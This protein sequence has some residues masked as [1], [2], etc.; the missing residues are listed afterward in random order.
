MTLETSHVNISL[1]LGYWNPYRVICLIEYVPEGVFH[2]LNLKHYF[3]SSTSTL[4]FKIISGFGLITVPLLLLLIFNNWYAMKVVCN[5]VAAS[6]QSI[7]QIHSNQV[8]NVLNDMAKYLHSMAYQDQNI[9]YI[10]QGKTTTEDDIVANLRLL[11]KIKKDVM[12]YSYANAIFLYKISE[13]VI[14]APKKESDY[15][16][17][18]SKLESLLKNNDTRL[19]CISNW[20]LFNMDGKY[21]LLKLTDTGFGTYIGV[22]VNLEELLQP[23]RFLEFS[24]NSQVMFASTEGQ[25]LT[26][27][28]SAHPLKTYRAD[29]LKKALTQDTRPYVIIKNEID[30]SDSMAVSIHSEVSDLYLVVV[31]PV[32][33]LV[34]KLTVFQS[35]VYVTPFVAAI[36]LAIFLLYL[37]RAIAHPV[38]KL[39][40][41]MGKIQAGDLTVR[42]EPSHLQEFN[43]INDAFNNMAHEVQYLKNGIYEEQLRV[44]K[45][46][47]KELQAQ[48]YPHFFANCLNLVY[49]LAQV[50]DT[51]LVKQLTLHMVRHLRFMMRTNRTLVTLSEELEHISNYLSIQKIRFPKAFDYSIEIEEEL[52]TVS[53]PAFILQPFVENCMEHGFCYREDMPFCVNVQVKA[54]SSHSGKYI[55]V[56]IED[57]GRGFA[58]EIISELQSENYFNKDFDNHIGI[59]NV[60][61]RC[62]LYYHSEVR[63]AFS[64]SSQGGAVVEMALP[65]SE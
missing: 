36:F 14:I 61:R 34:E 29:L 55:S 2:I 7:V 40:R 27:N 19:K 32:N 38:K 13:E 65:V 59:W 22:W 53:V 23:I 54:I 58:P 52:G 60:Q 17:I 35:V 6:N 28:T 57:N 42:I 47:M 10:N 43:T 48:I 12:E 30:G 24:D 64:N 49:S 26:A 51:E 3:S 63:L 4:T 50:K 46:E 45:A 39:L 1:G 5:Q 62:Q 8:D 31:L 56:K 21:F 20:Q 25:M 15:E 33:A 18:N 16:K 37:Q 9:I 44:Q 11:D 41:G